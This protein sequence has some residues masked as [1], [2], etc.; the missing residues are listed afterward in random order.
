MCLLCFLL[1][2]K[3][4]DNMAHARSGCDWYVLILYRTSV[5]YKKKHKG[6]I[7]IYFISCTIAMLATEEL[8]N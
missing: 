4:Q 8:I 7:F 1:N 2:E 6:N 3:K 5:F